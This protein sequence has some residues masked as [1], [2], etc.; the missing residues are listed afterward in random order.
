M[1]LN[2]LITQPRVAGAIRSKPHEHPLSL[3]LVLIV[4]IGSLA[5]AFLV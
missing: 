5:A 2:V 4:Q 3:L 1:L